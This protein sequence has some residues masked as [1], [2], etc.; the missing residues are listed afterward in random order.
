[1]LRAPNQT[2]LR[3]RH[4]KWADCPQHAMP[5]G[6]AGGP[7]LLGWLQDCPASHLHED[8]SSIRTL[9]ELVGHTGVMATMICTHVLKPGSAG[10][11][12]PVDG[13]QGHA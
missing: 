2:S 12:I 4:A 5:T 10:V 3:M 1:M 11:F 6:R 9:H 7:I 13:I 8:G